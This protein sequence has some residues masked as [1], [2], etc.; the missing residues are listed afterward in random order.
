MEGTPV[1]LSEAAA[2]RGCLLGLGSGTLH[3]EN[4]FTK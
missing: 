2:S 4:N 1:I 3:F